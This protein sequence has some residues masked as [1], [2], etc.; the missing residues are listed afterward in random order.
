MLVVFDNFKKKSQE[1]VFFSIHFR[2]LISN[3]FLSFENVCEKFNKL[4]HSLKLLFFQVMIF[5]IL[6]FCT[7]RHLYKYI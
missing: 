3:E 2:Y 7:Y 6:K 5:E 4:L 1:I